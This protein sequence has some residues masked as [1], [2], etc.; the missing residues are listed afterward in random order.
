MKLLV[1]GASGLLGL[2]LCL[3]AAPQH[4]VLGVARRR[5]AFAPFETVAADLLEGATVP[6]VLDS[7]G[8]DGVVHCAAAADLDYCE[9]HPELAR[10]LN[11]DVAEQIA[12]ECRA[13]RIRLVHISTDAVFDGT[14]EG[15]YSESDEPHPQGVYA[16]TKRDA[17]MAV[18]ASNPEAIMV[19]VNFYGWS[20]SGRRSLGEFFANN[21]SHGA[22]VLGFTD[23][24]FCPAFVGDLA[25][26]LL[27][28]LASDLH[29]VYHA[30]GKEAM[31][32][33]EFGTAIARKFGFDESLISPASVERSGL[34][35]RRS[36]NL[37]LATDKLSTDL[38]QSF[39]SFSTGLD[40]FH[41]QYL[42][43]FPQ[44]ISRYQQPAEV[45][46]GR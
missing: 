41:R 42:E 20:L 33:F 1:T 18:A 4:L 2:N 9:A 12:R 30:V 36:H 25:D 7:S 16:T 15:A 43:G 6:Q 26:T 27:K 37:W 32:K 11:T 22:A 23:V 44:R 13:R 28:L 31:S 14:K 19:R 21:L 34:S 24:T 5:L 17:E 35:A 40:K 46:P 3:Q 8:P 38:G 45:E 39:P 10:R 29:G